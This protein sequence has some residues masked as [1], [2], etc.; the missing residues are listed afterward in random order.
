MFNEGHNCLPDPFLEPTPDA[1]GDTEK[2]F[3]ALGHSRARSFQ[4]A[5]GIK[6]SEV[7]LVMLVMMFDILYIG[8]TFDGNWR[9]M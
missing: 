2:D 1:S 4:D 6:P 9:V 7:T 3:V 8:T 5:A